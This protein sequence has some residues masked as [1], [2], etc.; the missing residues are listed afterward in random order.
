MQPVKV[1]PNVYY[2]R[3]ESGMASAAN[4]GFMS[5]AGFVVTSDGVV[6][7]D[8]LAT[9][10][11]GKAMLKAIREITAKPV[12]HVFISHYHADH[13]YGLQPFK[14]QGAKIWAHEN[15]RTTL[16]SDFTLERLKQ[17][18][19]DLYPWV[20]D[21]TRLIPADQWLQFKDKKSIPF[22]LGTTSFRVIDA[23]GAHSPGDI[24]LFVEEQRVL[25]SGDLFFT[26]R[27]PFVGDAN[28]KSWLETLGHMLE[29]NPLMV[30]PGHGEMSAD[31]IKDM[32][33]TRDYLLFLREKMGKAV[34]EM[35]PFEEAYRNV[36]WSPFAKYPAF[37]QANRINA[38]GTYLL[39]EK[40]S[41]SKN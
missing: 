40:E 19:T 23:S 11:L 32:T 13:F 17:R 6:V 35:V 24:M 5:N 18:R 33:L 36:D 26:G 8:A 31:P 30:V 22:K 41:L 38:Y 16:N 2:F 21:D 28:S 25:F 39:M 4:K 34:E 27:I 12:K 14:A 15:E 37:E 3:G 29:T 10:V 9:P 20:N 1:A 7:F